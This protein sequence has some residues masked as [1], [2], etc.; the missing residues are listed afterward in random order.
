VRA[1]RRTRKRTK[2]PVVIVPSGDGP[3]RYRVRYSNG[4]TSEPVSLAEAREMMKASG[5]D[6]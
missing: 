4:T 3:G 6:Q 5:G 1:K 2:T